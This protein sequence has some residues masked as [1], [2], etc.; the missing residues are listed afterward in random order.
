MLFAAVMVMSG[1]AA[2]QKE[3]GYAEPDG[4][5]ISV[6]MTIATPD[7]AHTKAIGD[8]SKATEL[9]YA[10]FV[11]GIPVRSIQNKVAMQDGK[12][13]LDLALVKHVDY[14]FVFWAQAVQQEKAVLPY[15]LSDFYN[16]ATVTVNYQ[17]MA[18]DD[19]RDAFFAMAEVRIDDKANVE[20]VL[21]RPF[22]QINLC[23]SDYDMLKYLG[24]HAGMQSEASIYGLPD[25]LNVLDGSISISE[26][27]SASVDALFALSAIPSGDDEYI[28]VN[29]Q[30]YGYIGMNYVLA[31]DIGETI[32]LS[33][34]MKSGDNIWNTDL[35]H[36]VPVARNHKTHI[37]G[38]IFS[39]HATLQI[40]VIPD[41]NDPD[42]VVT[43]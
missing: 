43:M 13:V 19:S 18:N 1:L 24:L 28:T 31:S 30:Q 16:D 33:A 25:V 41:F 11:D 10:A 14:K 21:R 34:R 40:I 3:T 42:E 29:G 26:D 32:S 17:G 37:V 8:G 23:S 9:Y 15:D 36:N 35:L 38:D 5:R 20:V 39:E 12:V 4:A 22:A 27:S 6:K 2:C 7:M